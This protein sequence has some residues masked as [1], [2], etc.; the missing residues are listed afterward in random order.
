MNNMGMTRASILRS[1]FVSSTTF[2]ALDS[3]MTVES[4]SRATRT[5]CFS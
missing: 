2:L 3:A 5:P 1:S 4:E